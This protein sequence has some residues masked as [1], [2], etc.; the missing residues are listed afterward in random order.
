MYIDQREVGTLLHP[1][2]G[3]FISFP[4]VIAADVELQDINRVGP[5]N[6]RRTPLHCAAKGGNPVC[7]EALIKVSSR[8]RY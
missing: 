1:L 5:N 3:V 7:V 6:R 2:S 8:D 4:C